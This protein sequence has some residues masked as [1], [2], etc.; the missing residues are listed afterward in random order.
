MLILVLKSI[1]ICEMNSRPDGIVSFLFTDI[2]GSTMLA[3]KFPESL[4][5]ALTRHH[6][7][8][9]RAIEAHNGFVFEIIG[10]AFCAAF[11]EPAD[12]INAACDVQK[13]LIS[14]DWGNTPIK[15]RIGINTGEALWN[16]KGYTGYMT[17]SRTQRVMSVAYGEQIIISNETYESVKE[18]SRKEFSFRDL[19]ERRLKSLIKP[20]HLYQVMSEGLRADFPPLKTLDARP[21]NLPIQ[22]TS[23]IGRRK[24]M[25]EIKHLLS[26]THLLTLL[27]PGGTG[28][29]RIALQTGADMIDDFPHGVWYVELAQLSDPALVVQE[30]AS[31]FNIKETGSTML[32]DILIEYLR[33]KELL[34]I[35]DNC[36]HLIDECAKI[37]E[38]LIKN[39]M[40]LKIIATS[41][42]TLRIAGETIFRVPTLT[43]PDIQDKHTV[44][45]LFAHE[46]SR[47]FIERAISVKTDFDI[48]AESILPIAQI[49][50][51]LDGIPFA[52]ELAAARVRSLP[53]HKIAE[54]LVD[55]F[56]FLTGGSRTALPHQQT[57][58]ATIDWSYDLLNDKEKSLLRRLSVFA[59]GWSLEAAEEV[60]SYNGVKETEILDLLNYL[61]DKSLINFDEQKDRYNMFETVRQYG[62]E[63]IKKRGEYSHFNTKHLDYFRKLAEEYEPMLSEADPGN[64]LN[65]LENDH[66]NLRGA[67]NWS[68][69]EKCNIES[70]QRLA[71][72]LRSFWSGHSYFSEG[73]K[74]IDEMLA[75]SNDKKIVR[76]KLLKGAGMLASR[77]GN[78]EKAK[79]L[80]E[81][82]LQIYREIGD[83]LSIANIL[84]NLGITYSEQGEYSKSKPLY[85]EALEINRSNNYK[86]GIANSLNNLGALETFRGNYSDAKNFY[87]QALEIYRGIGDKHD[88]ASTLIGLGNLPLMNETDFIE[89]KAIL[90]EALS[91]FSETGDKHGIA[92]SH[93]SLGNLALFQCR[94]KEAGVHDREALNILKEIGNKRGIAF[95]LGNLG[96]IAFLSN[97]SALALRNLDEALSIHREIGCKYGVA[98][99]L[100][101]MGYISLENGDTNRAWVQF[102]EAFTINRNL[103]DK[104]GILQSLD[105]VAGFNIKAGFFS[106]A[107]ML[108]GA[109]DSLRE[110][111]G[112]P[113]LPYQMDR[114]KETV[115]RLIEQLGEEVF[116][117]TWNEGKLLTTDDAINLALEDNNYKKNKE[118]P[119]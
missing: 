14:E 92:Y 7:I 26:A 21:N 103:E 8:L 87:R 43:V 97:D 29:T 59:G 95:Q 119:V 32:M 111:I 39:N 61:V 82:A 101:I 16:G 66:D 19:G 49:C 28:K 79:L 51:Y 45:S 109:A 52:I 69:K 81:E 88:I 78:Y 90:E 62:T 67:L 105:A 99:A 17:L 83:S 50:N 15:V 89:A 85:D 75:C 11:E 65:L 18:I 40:K 115:F 31:V 117:K 24:E 1:K 100:N 54:R 34:I 84:D 72:A 41:R 98:Q 96:E 114:Y 2:E 46:S 30:I 27:G 53:V 106:K 5:A 76:G 23:F 20:E 86:L 73:S 68:L 70:G 6:E 116:R 57:L 3:Q 102:E 71:G 110:K 25:D 104:E 33:E 74:F 48:K 13:K 63:K 22:S 94:Y 56:S 38:T 113:L 55:R 47:L 77:Q 60:C 9:Q 35:L 112:S 36:E 4:P 118:K 80:L 108:T 107:A 10:D 44:E 91:I 64:W 58:L 37:S 42:E 93:A 12:A